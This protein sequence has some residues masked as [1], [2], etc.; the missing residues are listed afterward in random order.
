MAATK[1]R[2]RPVIEEIVE[3]P[4]P[5]AHEPEHKEDHAHHHHVHVEEVQKPET[6][7][8]HEVASYD[9]PPSVEPVRHHENPEAAAREFLG[10]DQMQS[11]PEHR[12]NMK[13][14]FFVT[15]LTAL[16][17]GFIAGGVYVYVTGVADN[18]DLTEVTPV[19]SP[20]GNTTD[21]ATTPTPSAKPVVKLD[22]LTVNVLNGSGIIGAAGKVKASLENAGFKV[23][24]TGNAANYNFKN[25]VIQVK[26]GTSAEVID[27]LKK[28]LSDYVVE[29]GDA[30]AASSKFDIVVTAGK[31]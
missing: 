30:L 16:I 25:T 9:E 26:T 6:E 13:L 10:K 21:T 1:R 17:V 24:G 15:I 29:E 7:I 28:S 18:T 3:T 5:A 2:I 31:Q 20:S 22:T 23:T 19:P 27:A 4:S 8:M 12:T 14:V 11:E